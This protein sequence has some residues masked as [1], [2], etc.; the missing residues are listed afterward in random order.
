MRKGFI[1]LLCICLFC[2][3]SACGQQQPGNEGNETIPA[4]ESGMDGSGESDGGLAAYSDKLFDQSYVHQID[5]RLADADWANLLADPTSKTKYTA[6]VTIDGETYSNV[7]FSTKGFSSLYFVA[8]GEEESQRYSFKINFGKQEEGQNYYGLDKLH[9]NNLY[10]DDTWMK[11]LMSYDLFR[12]AGI[13][14]PL[15]SYVWL[16]VNGKDQGLYTAVEPVEDSYM[17]RVY[18]G[19]GVIY[20]VETARPENITREMV[21]YIFKNGFQGSNE[22]NGADLIYKGDDLSNYTD[23]FDHAETEASEEDYQRVADALRAL[24]TEENLEEHFDMDEII[25]F[26]AVHNYLLNYDSYTSDQMSNLVLH[27]KDGRLSVIPWD[28]NLAFGTYPTVIGFETLE[29]ATGLINTGI[30]TPLIN[31]KEEERPLWNVIRDNPE[32]LGRYHE[33]LNM[34]LE[35]HLSDGS[36]EAKID[37]TKQMLLPWVQKD[38][39]AFCTADEFETACESL[40]KFYTYR[41]ESVRRQLAGELSTVSGEQEPQAMVDVSDLDIMSMGA[42]ALGKK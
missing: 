16:T 13:E 38:P 42:L 7:V 26:F 39:T 3:G 22:S 25:R 15:V 6:Q 37:Q 28:Y 36:F 18:Q 34:L 23:I 35:E 12:D 17:N 30:D 31:T 9:L 19:D 40:K 5:I 27:E 33:V 11:D 2:L 1:I 10:C 20:G 4:T 14:A 32:Y 41:T 21:E 24:S 8:Y 29:D